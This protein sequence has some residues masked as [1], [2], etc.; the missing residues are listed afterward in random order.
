MKTVA[1]M[2]Q[3]GGVGKTT[4]AV[5]LGHG[6]ALRGHRALIVDLDAQGNVAD[7]LGV[8]KRGDLYELLVNGQMTITH[9]GRPGLDLI[10]GD[11]RTVEAKAILIGR[12]FRE[13]ALA[14]ALAALDDYDVVILDV[15]PGVDVL[16]VGALVAA[17]AFLIPAALD[18][19]A[20]VG[21]GDAMASAAALKSAGGMGGR[22]L[23]ILPTFWERATNESQL[24]LEFLAA[25]FGVWVWEP[26]PRDTKAREATAHGQTL[27]EYAPGCRALEGVQLNGLATGERC[28]G[29]YRR[30]L[31]RLMVEMEL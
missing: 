18:H 7:A 29:G 9:S 30:V 26:V 25:Q 24:Q 12:P 16:Q 31:E 14:K 6:L 8:E 20:V 13:H 1:I 10:L 27:W 11:K 5:T 19:L 23:G 3:K 22:F 28:V 17:D 2:N 4:T 21:V 15:A